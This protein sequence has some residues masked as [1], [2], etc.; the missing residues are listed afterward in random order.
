MAAATRSLERV[1]AA[2]GALES[3]PVE[4]QATCD[5]A[6][7]GVLLALPALLAVGLLRRTPEFYQL[8]NG[9]YG[10]ESL[11]LLLAL[12]ALA[13]IRSLEQLRYQAPGEWPR[14]YS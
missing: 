4:F 3:A 10:I 14:P 1:A 9:F 8:P 12:M 13:R 11:F 7:G 6:Q 2:M 5:V